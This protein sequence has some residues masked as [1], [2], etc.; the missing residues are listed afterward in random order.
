LQGLYKIREKF[1]SCS[2]KIGPSVIVTIEPVWKELIEIKKRAGKIR[3]LTEITKDNI[4]FCKELMKIGELRHFDGVKVNFAILDGKEYQATII[5]E[6]SEPVT[7]LIVSNAKSFVD[8]H[9]YV[10][11]TLWSRA[12]PGEQ[13][14]K[15]IQEGIR[16]DFAD[17]IHDYKEIQKINFNLIKSAKKEILVLFLTINAFH[18]HTQLMQLFKEAAKERG[19]KIRILMPAANEINDAID[20]LK[21]Q[22]QINIQYLKKSFQTNVTVFVVDNVFSLTVESK[23]DREEN[24]KATYSNIE[25]TAISYASIFETLWIEPPRPSEKILIPLYLMK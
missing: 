4:P 3:L 16:P 2:D 19:V 5:H 12:I 18:Q 11:D 23:R 21:E 15:E 13:K 22:Q 10:F 1:D 9:Q 14:I 20:V 6:E 7:Q 24:T 25:S 8:Q 17:V